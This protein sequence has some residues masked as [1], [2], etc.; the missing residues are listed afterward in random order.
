MG[1]T[2]KG[3]TVRETVEEG[4]RVVRADDVHPAGTC[5]CGEWQLPSQI[6][7]FPELESGPRQ[8]VALVT[9]PKCARVWPC[10]LPFKMG[11]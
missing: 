2:E 7:V 11:S 8:H 5:T 10:P 9:C 3:E 6:G 1:T 4:V